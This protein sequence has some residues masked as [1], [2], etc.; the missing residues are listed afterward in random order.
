MGNKSLST[1]HMIKNWIL[2]LAILLVGLV[3]LSAAENV[4]ISPEEFEF[5]E[6]LGSGLK[7]ETWAAYPDVYSPV[8]MDVDSQGRIWVVEDWHQRKVDDGRTGRG[9]ILIMEDT[10]LD[11]K[12][13]KSHSFGPTFTSI[14]LG[15]TIF[16]NK[17]IIAMAPDLIVYTDVNR[18]ARFDEGVDKKEILL[19]GF[20]GHSHDHSLHGVVG[21]PDG[22]WHFSQGN[23]GMNVKTKDNRHIIASSYYSFNREDIGKM[24]SDGHLYVG[25]VS[26]AVKPDGTGL[27]VLSQNTRNTHDMSIS[28]FGNIY[29]ADNDDPA[30]ARATWAMKH[31]NFG[32]A[33]LED[34][35]RSWE[36]AAKSWEEFS[37]DPDLLSV[38]RDARSSQS[39][40]RENYPGTT[41]PDFVFGSGA[42][43]GNIFVENNELS[44]NLVGHLL[45]AETVN[46]AIFA[47]NPKDLGTHIQMGPYKEFLSL[48][49]I[50][51]DKGFLPT[52]VIHGLDGS[53]YV[54][55]WNSSNNRRGRGGPEGA[56]YRISKKNELRIQK[57]DI[58]YSSTQGQL[59]ALSNP[60]RSIRFAAAEKLR[61]TQGNRNDIINY[62][63]KQE[64]EYLK[65]RGIWLLG[66]KYWIKNREY[67]ENLLNDESPQIRLTA[68]RVLKQSYPKR[69]L[70]YARKVVDD[71]FLGMAREAALSLR[72]MPTGKSQGLIKRIIEKYDGSNKWFLEAI[73]TASTGKEKEIYNRVVKK[74]GNAIPY[75]KWNNKIKNLAWRLR[76]P[77]ALNDLRHV[78]IAQKPDIKEFRHLL[79]SYALAYTEEERA[80][81]LEHVE[82]IQKAPQFQSEE[83][84]STIAEILDKDL[85]DRQ[86]IILQSSYRFPEAYTNKPTKLSDI[87]T[88]A[89]LDPNIE[90][91]R[92]K[93]AICL[94]CHRMNDAGVSFGP[95]LTNW[96]QARTD[97]VVIQAMLEPSIE[98][99]H[100]FEKVV[101]V[102]NRTHRLEG[103]DVGYSWHAGA[104][105]VKTVAGQTVKVAFRKSGARI[106]RLEKHSWM[107]SA[108]DLGFSDQDV[109]DVTAYLKSIK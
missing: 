57:I 70:T 33:S 78:I 60:S 20:E 11:G 76:T 1:I 49:E 88:I 34:G 19:T 62:I 50:A 37:V 22:L 6:T 9:N 67:V 30:H 32:Y 31:S 65:A 90:N 108:S 71:K 24:S 86:A 72:D 73:G 12:A 39:H 48:K 69:I 81:N 84:Q 3:S 56:I 87:Q 4:L 59:K 41:P 97:Q 74:S 53:L 2:S 21:G 42:P 99:A 64:N 63:E 100:G 58:D 36:E 5:E 55:D 101:V 27:M 44:P 10:D 105:K 93:S 29:Q 40:W 102:A 94:T 68:F 98:L 82:A 25:G 52:E 61:N 79:M 16:D 85:K 104:I 83:Y 107:P 45:V 8:A 106:Q 13:D 46:K 28:S 38:R 26:L 80:Q 17:I 95:N 66:R 35:G 89:A 77:E 23:C 75:E 91:G 47:F 43:M 103:I 109:R 7:I 15:I 14:P 92:L 96:A 18:N 54:S 51:K